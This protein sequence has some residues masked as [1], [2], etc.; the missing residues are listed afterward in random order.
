M[1]EEIDKNLLDDSD[2]Q[3]I[4]FD[5]YRLLSMYAEG[6]SAADIALVFGWV[7]PATVY[8]HLKQFPKEYKEA[9]QQ[10]LEKRNAK[11]RRAGALAIDIQIESLE[12]A[13]KLLEQEQPLIEELNKLELESIDN[14]YDEMLTKTDTSENQKIIIRKHNRR[15]E[16]IQDTLKYI[17][18]IRSNI[19]DFKDV[20]ES[21]ERRADLNEGKPTERT[22][23]INRPMTVSEL[24]AHLKAIK[25]AGTGLDK[26]SIQS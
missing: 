24:E 4:D 2:S 11:Y 5:S 9:K 10:L 12:N 7:S 23:D 14:S 19:K 15:I 26:Q 21:A 16:Q 1:T 22:E 17:S 6:V 13:K 20:G 25:D 18:N 8:T 3:S